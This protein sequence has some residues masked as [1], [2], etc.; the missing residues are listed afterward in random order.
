MPRVIDYST[1]LETLERSGLRC[2]Y[3][4]SGAFGLPPDIANHVI[5][6]AAAD[7]PTIRPEARAALRILPQPASRSL[8]A[9]LK[10]AWQE[11][12][13]G[14]L[15]LMPA[16]HWAYELQF[17]GGEWLAPLLSEL[18]IDPESLR[19]R[20]DGSAIGF[21]FAEADSLLAVVEKV[22][23]RLVASDFTVAFPGRA[24]VAMLHHH[25]Q[26]WWQT[27]EAAIGESID[28]LILA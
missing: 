28:S 11:H 17:G 16:S 15:W 10:R 7:D 5:G 26:I 9:L 19:S 21:E 3:P 20:A 12:L 1:V 6:W 27:S 18:G 23:D 22:L 25:Q 2:V 14:P 4:N 8:T 13:P 24:V